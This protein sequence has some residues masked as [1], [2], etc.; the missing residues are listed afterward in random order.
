MAMTSKN[1][2]TISQPSRL[3]RYET[4]IRAKVGNARLGILREI[5]ADDPSNENAMLVTLYIACRARE[6]EILRKCPGIAKK[7]KE[8]K[9]EVSL[10]PN[11]YVTLGVVNGRIAK[12]IRNRRDGFDYSELTK[13]VT[14]GRAIELIAEDK[15]LA[16]P[17]INGN[18][19]IVHPTD[20]SLN[21]YELNY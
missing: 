7:A 21:R 12:V 4:K 16:L 6:I 13:I 8:V 3:L 15:G 2:S 10:L 18:G 11:E 14:R 5:K 9:G 1:K 17:H 19:Q 20:E